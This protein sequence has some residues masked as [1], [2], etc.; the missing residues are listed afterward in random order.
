MTSDFNDSIHNPVW[1]RLTITDLSL[2]IH[3]SRSQLSRP[4]SELRPC[5][6][7]SYRNLTD[8][9]LRPLAGSLLLSMILFLAL[10]PILGGL[11]ARTL[12]TC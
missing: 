5:R 3:S 9:A 6:I 10:K 11:L 7:S 4:G 12:V 8:L 1:V 2:L